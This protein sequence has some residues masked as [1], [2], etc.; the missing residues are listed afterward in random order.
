MKR[1]L[2]Y[3]TV[4]LFLGCLALGYLDLHQRIQIA[5]VNLDWGNA[6]KD[7]QKQI[8]D[9]QHQLTESKAAKAAADRQIAKLAQT[10]PSGSQNQGAKGGPKIIHIGDILKDHPEYSGL[11]TKMMRRNV[12]RMYGD[13]LT[14]LNLPPDQ[15]AQLKDLLVQR[16]LSQIDAQGAA[17]AAGLQ[18]GTPEWNDAIKQAAQDSEQQISTL[19]GGNGN[20][21]LQQLQARAGMQNQVQFTYAPDFAEAGAP[22]TPE[23]TSGLVQAMA[24]ANYAG[25][26]LSTRPAGYNNVDPSTGLSPHDDRI[27][28]SATSVLTAA[29][30][31]ILKQDQIENEQMSSI[32]REYSKGGPVMFQP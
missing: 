1:L 31:Q 5:Q 26:D 6:D 25:K 11:Y 17:S 27:I 12:L 16:Q 3:L 32:M 24:D 15:F 28:N 20:A 23:Q 30:V 19:L 29:Q 10:A 22:L 9:L 14:T 13:A 18:Q 8:A 21:I 2:P 7:A 4:V